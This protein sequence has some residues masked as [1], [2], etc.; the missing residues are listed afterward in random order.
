VISVALRFR[1]YSKKKGEK[2]EE[3]KGRKKGKKRGETGDDIAMTYYGFSVINRGVALCS[4]PRGGLA[5]GGVREKKE[6]EKKKKKKKK[7]RISI[8]TLTT[9]PIPN[10]CQ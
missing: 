4:V 8:S 10:A 6:G 7:K 5:E 9:T 1:H 2:K 3:E